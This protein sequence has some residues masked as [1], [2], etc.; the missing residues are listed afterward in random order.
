MIIFNYGKRYQV[1]NFWEII[2]KNVSVKIYFHLENKIRKCSFL[3]NKVKRDP[4]GR[5]DSPA[6]ALW[7]TPLKWNSCLSRSC[8]YGRKRKR[9]AVCAAEKQQIKRV[10][11]GTEASWM[12]FFPQA[13]SNRSGQV[14]WW[15]THSVKSRLAWHPVCPARGTRSLRESPNCLS[16]LGPHL[17]VRPATGCFLPAKLILSTHRPSTPP[18]RRGE[19]TF[20]CKPIISIFIQSLSP[21]L[22]LSATPPRH[23]RLW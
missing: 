15:F 12:S 8:R 1:R 19:S 22:T 18:I 23:F 20:F 21:P 13:Q 16:R 6:R 10:G 7:I 9:A 3:H 17:L 4:V 11:T 2:K 5:G 14:T